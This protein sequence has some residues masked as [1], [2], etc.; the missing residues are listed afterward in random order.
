[1]KRKLKIVAMS[2][3]KKDDVAKTPDQAQHTQVMPSKADVEA[4][5]RQ[6]AMA[7]FESELVS[8]SAS[9]EQYRTMKVVFD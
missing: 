9:A 1:M 8:L 7:Q 4:F 6:A 3:H 2:A 5:A